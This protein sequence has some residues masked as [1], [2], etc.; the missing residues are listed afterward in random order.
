MKRQDFELLTN[1]NIFKYIIC[2]GIAR[3]TRVLLELPCYPQFELEMKLS[4]ASGKV[5]IL[6]DFN[7]F[8]LDTSGFAYKRFVDIFET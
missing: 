2:G 7:I 4:C 1:L 8:F 6:G 3:F 5:I